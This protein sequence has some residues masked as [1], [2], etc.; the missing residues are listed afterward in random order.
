MSGVVIRDG[1]RPFSDSRPRRSALSMAIARIGT[2]SAKL[3]RLTKIDRTELMPVQLKAVTALALNKWFFGM[4]GRWILEMVG[5][6]LHVRPGASNQL[7][8]L[9]VQIAHA[10]AVADETAECY[11]CKNPFRP[12]RAGSGGIRRYCSA[13]RKAKVPGAT[14]LEIGGK[15]HGS[16]L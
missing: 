13:C 15:G 7:G 16:K 1:L 4:P 9:I 6:Q 5:D 11:G 14:S 3:A 8:L 2:Q 12:K 10:M